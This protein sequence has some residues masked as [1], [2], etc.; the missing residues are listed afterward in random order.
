MS[1]H[2]SKD[3]KEGCGSRKSFTPSTYVDLKLLVKRGLV[4][5]IFL[6]NVRCR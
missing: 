5:F 6:V 3:V 1:S 2:K 4:L